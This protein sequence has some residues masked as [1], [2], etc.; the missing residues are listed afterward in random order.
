MKGLAALLKDG[1]LNRLSVDEIMEFGYPREVA[2]RIASGE[3]PMDEASRAVR[4]ETF[5]PVLYRGHDWDNPP[6]SNSNMWMTDDRDMAE[7]YAWDGE[8]TP[9]RHNAK[10]LFEFD[11]DGEWHEDIYADPWML[12]GVD[13]DDIN[14]NLNGTE[15]IS[16]TVERHGVHQGSL[17]RNIKDD[18]YPP[19][20]YTEEEMLE[21][22]LDE[23]DL[24]SGNVGDVYNIL[25]ERPEVKIRHR[26]AAYDPKYNGPNIMGA[27]AAG[28]IGL[29][30]LTQSEDAEAI[31]LGTGARNAAHDMLGMAKTMKHRGV[32]REEI[33]QKTG[34]HQGVDGKWRFEVNDNKMFLPDE[35]VMK[36]LPDPKPGTTVTMDEG[37]LSVQRDYKYGL[38][39]ERIGWGINPR[40]YTGVTGG[41][42]MINYYPAMAHVDIPSTKVPDPVDVRKGNG[43]YFHGDGTAT[44]VPPL[45]EAVLFDPRWNDSAHT[46]MELE[47]GTRLYL[48]NPKTVV[49]QIYAPQ[50]AFSAVDGKRQAERQYQSILAHETQHAVQHLEGFNRGGAD[51]SAVLDARKYANDEVSYIS[52]KY[53]S[54]HYPTVDDVN[55]LIDAYDEALQRRMRLQGSQGDVDTDLLS[56]EQQSRLDDAINDIEFLETRFP[57]LPEAHKRFNESIGRLKRAERAQR[58]EGRLFYKNLAGEVEARNDQ[59]RLKLTDEERRSIPPWETEDVPREKQYAG[60]YASNPFTPRYSPE[61]Y[62]FASRMAAENVLPQTQFANEV[63]DLERAG[64]D[65]LEAAALVNDQI[66]YERNILD[67]DMELYTDWRT[68]T[69]EQQAEMLA[70][71]ERVATANP[72]L[73]NSPYAAAAG[74]AL[75][76]A[77]AANANAAEAGQEPG[78]LEQLYDN[79]YAG[80]QAQELGDIVT[81][82]GID[83]MVDASTGIDF[84]PVVNDFSGALFDVTASRNELNETAR[85]IL[86]YGAADA[87]DPTA[88][89]QIAAV[90]QDAGLYDGNAT[91]AQ[92][93]GDTLATIGQ[94]GYE[95][96]PPGYLATAPGYIAEA[97]QNIAEGDG[98]LMD[99]ATLGV[100][101]LFSAVPGGRSTIRG[102]LR[103]D[104]PGI[105]QS[106]DDLMDQ[107]RVEPETGVLEEVF[108]ATRQDLADIGRTRQGN[109]P[110]A[111]PNA[112]ARPKGTPQGEMIMKPANTA[113]LVNS[114]ENAMGSELEKGMSGWY[115][116]DPL[117]D[118]YRALGLSEEEAA[119]RFRDFQAFT[120]IH[121][122]ASDVKTELTRGTG[123]LYL[124]EQGRMDDYVNYGG[125]V[126]QPGAPEDMSRFPG[127]FAHK[128]AHGTPLL[129]Y[130]ENGVLTMQSPKVPLYIQSAG[131][132]QTG[133]QTEMPVGDAHFS[134]AI[135]L[136]DTRPD[137]QKGAT[138]E[139]W[140]TPEAQQLTPWWREEVAGQVGLESVPAQ[141]L[142]WGLFS[143]QTGVDTPVGVPKLEILAQMIKERAAERGI[144]VEQARDEILMAQDYVSSLAAK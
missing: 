17:F 16:H 124:N 23:D 91:A 43:G 77:A 144:S 71:A 34:W 74:A 22:G 38:D 104:Y 20:E 103:K 60:V 42:E 133:F 48:E 110:A 89:N 99:Y 79:T 7:T 131:V 137:K 26:D 98:G 54:K 36:T 81:G 112:A 46:G 11:A 95:M 10:N 132:P 73:K 2:E 21:L 24:F 33:L 25:G 127:H 14:F 139:S 138:N 52:E 47:D 113:R 120:G 58:S 121:S 41:A 13:I 125:K 28:A 8:V 15:G 67:R 96:T 63:Q 72:G 39:G 78:V 37:G 35:G 114:L 94:M 19:T 118:A 141:A 49:Q 62:G 87:V 108:G 93:T 75:T 59:Y 101:A 142:A 30:A 50:A 80:Q 29:G 88:G 65:R 119:R 12:P 4:S 130:I 136:A 122:S 66:E 128:T 76:A 90:L 116:M 32:P 3:L 134:R 135:G 18:K 126:G 40:D 69:P 143:P 129:N 6:D 68:A 9:L 109:Q 83:Q 1:A 140:T 31:F 107:V 27:T 61:P 86:Q 115:V 123:A 57:Y 97:Q 51:T 100:E 105:Y 64:M 70:E 117:Y 45:D 5:S 56:F 53:G 102:A 111:L 92:K 55:P 44:K 82:L 85:D 84:N 106:P